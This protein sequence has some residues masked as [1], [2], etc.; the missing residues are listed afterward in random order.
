[1]LHLHPGKVRAT[2]RPDGPKHESPYRKA[3]VQL[4]TAVYSIDEFHEISESGVVGHPERA[5][6]VKGA[7]FFEAIVKDVS[8]FLPD[9]LKW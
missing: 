8:A 2:A 6:A 3:D 1:M 9:F 5:T 4:A 7:S